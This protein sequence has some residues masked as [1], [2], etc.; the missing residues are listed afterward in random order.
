[1]FVIQL[2][3]LSYPYEITKSLKF[4]VTQRE[5]GERKKKTS[6]KGVPMV[7]ISCN[8]SRLTIIP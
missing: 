2:K 3:T 7:L 6:L 4:M 1:M 8:K 5:V